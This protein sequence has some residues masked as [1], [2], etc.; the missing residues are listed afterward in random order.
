MYVPIL[1]FLKPKPS[2]NVV[3]EDADDCTTEIGMCTKRSIE[4]QRALSKKHGKR[5]TARNRKH[6]V[7]R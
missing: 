4:R 1:G 6:D 3:R 5:P 2:F 7:S